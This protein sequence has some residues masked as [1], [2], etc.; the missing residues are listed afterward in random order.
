MACETAG[1]NKGGA[2]VSQNNWHAKARRLKPPKV[3]TLQ[4]KN[5]LSLNVCFSY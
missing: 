4:F 2:L 5:P 1:N 3:A